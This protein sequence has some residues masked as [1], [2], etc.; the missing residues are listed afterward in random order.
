MLGTVQFGLPYGVANR[1]G[2][3]DRQQVLEIVSAAMDGGVNCFDTAAEYGTS[4]EVLGDVFAELGVAERVCV[5]TKVRP[6]TDE[7]LTDPRLA[8]I[9]IETSVAV[10]RERLR[11]DCLPVVMFHRESN[12]VH[13]PVLERLQARGWIRHAGVSCDNQPGFANQAVDDVGV[14]ALQI[15]GN[16][17]DHRHRQSGVF[18]KAATNGVAVFIRSVF[19]QGLLLMPE[20]DVPAPLRGVLPLRR[21]LASIA[22][23]GGMS[24]AELAVRF[25]LSLDGVTC[26]LTGVETVEQIRENIA[27]FE[28]GPLPINMMEAIH[29]DA[30][31][32][33]ESILTPSQWESLDSK[34]K[35]TSRL[36]YR[37]RETDT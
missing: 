33:P 32:L 34:P 29:A 2:Q 26:V 8:A 14:A 19:L 16:V 37:A 35:S 36:R 22:S 21:K 31:E 18:E 11:I 15:P 7:Q 9:A 3:P 28:R 10:S 6:L 27:V 12:A 13:L 23:D 30:L 25:M 20:Q 4:E 24:L 5:V 17:L 1:A